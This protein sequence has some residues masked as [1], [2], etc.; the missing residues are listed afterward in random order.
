MIFL[1]QTNNFKDYFTLASPIVVIL[2]FIIDGYINHKLR[3][4]EVNRNWYLKVFIEPSI[5]KIS[6]FYCYKHNLITTGH[7]RDRFLPRI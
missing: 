5:L 2:L 4:R 7:E 1:C 6:T 3:K